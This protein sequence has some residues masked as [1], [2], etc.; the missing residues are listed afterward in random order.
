[1]PTATDDLPWLSQNFYRIGVQYYVAGRFSILNGMTPV[2][3]NLFHHA[4]EMLLKGKLVYLHPLSQ[5]KNWSHNLRKC[6]RA[7]KAVFPADDLTRFDKFIVA[8]DQFEELRYPERLVEYGASIHFGWAPTSRLAAPSTSSVPHYP[9]SVPDLDE[10]MGR[11]FD[12]C[13]INPQDYLDHYPN[14]KEFVVRHNG[15]CSKWFPEQDA[16]RQP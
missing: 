6:W 9:L 8:L 10:L 13:R 3:G 4:V 11:L 2:A 16:G 7:F 1:V 5:L 15:A 14:V 12:L